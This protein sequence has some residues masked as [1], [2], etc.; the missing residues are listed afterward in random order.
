MSQNMYK[1]T[2]RYGM[3]KDKFIFSPYWMTFDLQMIKIPCRNHPKW[4]R[5]EG[6]GGGHAP[7]FAADAVS[8]GIPRP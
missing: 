2:S 5:R 3:S 4:R 7:L 8:Y 1:Y 6:Q